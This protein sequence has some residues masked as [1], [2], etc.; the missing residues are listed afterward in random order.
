MTIEERLENM[1]R[2]LGHVKRRNRWLLGAVL[3]MAGGLVIPAVFKTT[4]FRARAQETEISAYK[5]NI[6]D[7]SGK[8]CGFLGMGPYG[9]ALFMS[10]ILGKAS[11]IIASEPS[12]PRIDLYD[13]TGRIIWSATKR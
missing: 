4:A 10:N 3:L 9:P 5:F 6:L 13:D 11:V 8:V 12:G 2:E 1:E 7:N